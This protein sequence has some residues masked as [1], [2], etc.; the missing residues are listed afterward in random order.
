MRRVRSQGAKPRQDSTVLT[1]GEVRPGGVQPCVEVVEHYWW[2]GKPHTELYA[3]LVDILKNVWDCRRIV[4]DAT[5]IGQPVSSFL[6]RELGSRVSPFTFTQQSKS[7]LG[8]K[9][10]AAVNSGSLKVYSCDGSAACREFWAEMEMAKNHYRPSRTV[11]FYVDPAQGH[12]DFLMSLALL[13]EAVS[14][15]APR[16]ARGRS[17]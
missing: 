15:Y 3:Q 11:N 12:D 2:T 14:R 9:L 5:G 4:I 17:I 16:E 7:E 10:L 6:R 13:V 8:F 1:I